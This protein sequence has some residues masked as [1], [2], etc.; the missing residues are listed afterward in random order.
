MM[1]MRNIITVVFA[2]I[3]L[4]LQNKDIAIPYLQGSPGIGKTQ[5]SL[6]EAHKR[7]INMLHI[8]FGLIPIEEISGIPTIKN[9]D[10]NGKEIPGTQWTLPEILS[11]SYELSKSE[12]PVLIFID[13]AHL[14]S[15]AHLA[16]MFE[17]FTEKSLRSY[18]FPKNSAFVLAGN[19]SAKA[20]AKTMF[21][22]IVNRCAVYPVEA[23][24]DYWKSNFA[25]KNNVNKKVLAF[26]SNE[27]YQTKYFS[28]EELVNSP[29]PSPRAW[30]RLGNLLNEMEAAN[31]NPKTHE[32][33]YYSAAHVGGEA[34]GEFSA[35]YNLYSQTNMDEIFNK[36]KKII[37]PDNNSERYIFGISAVNEFSGRIIKDEKDKKKIAESIDIF[38]DI[39]IGISVQASEI[40]FSMI[41]ELIEIEKI[42]KKNMQYSALKN[43]LRSKNPE[44]ENK[45]TNDLINA[46]T[47][48]EI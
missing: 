35:F 4:Q 30:T 15:P 23:D 14:C 10:F 27:R 37:I 22:A 7:G 17:M 31:L 48:T 13:D 29:W 2:Q 12:K 16:L 40:G 32:I 25:I 24:F 34:G 36:T 43:S 33:S 11:K 6:H 5:I 41:K 44:I 42:L 18:P 19:Q 1:N 8:H 28:G 3:A 45:L 20:G 9:I 26:L 47:A 21:S 46:S 39:L 38:T